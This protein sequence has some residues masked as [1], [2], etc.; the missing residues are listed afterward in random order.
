MSNQI[1]SSSKMK[2][3]ASESTSMFVLDS[4]NIRLEINATTVNSEW[5]LSILQK[6]PLYLYLVR[7]AK[8]SRIPAAN[9]NEWKKFI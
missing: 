5:S 7:K 9:Y 6:W 4:N 3:T 8:Q 2:L 1:N